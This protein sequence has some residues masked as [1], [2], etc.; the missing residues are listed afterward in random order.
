MRN[1]V[2]VPI[3]LVAASITLSARQA[4]SV[5][6]LLG[7]E[8]VPVAVG[9]LAA[10][11]GRFRALGFTL[12][13]GRHH[14][15]G[16]QN[17]HA[18]FADGSYIELITAPAATDGLTSHYRAFLS[19]GDG[20]AFA[21]LYVATLSGLAARLAPFAAVEEGGTVDFPAGPLS[22][23]FFG[24]RERSPTDRPEYFAHA[25]GATGLTRLW[26]A[27]ADPRPL[28][29]MAERLGARFLPR[30][31]CLPVCVDA[32]IARLRQ[33]EIVLLPARE[34]TVA[35]REVVGVTI[36]V[37]SLAK[38]RAVLTA[39]GTGPGREG[40]S[41]R[42]QSIFVPPPLANGLRLEFSTR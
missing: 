12:K 7:T 24:T 4:P 21:S 13:P 39:S 17:A 31:V 11:E 22:P 41:E 18:K 32:Q 26:L 42:G 9:D 40:V 37:A 23:F 2:R 10:A 8:H 20:P 25:N 1:L 27:P 14:E 3:L 15:N 34:Q 29:A 5:P 28:R 38:T 16:I 36:R 19:R 35:G 6:V 30:R 33:G